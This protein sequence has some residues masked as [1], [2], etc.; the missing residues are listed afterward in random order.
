M[1]KIRTCDDERIQAP[2]ITGNQAGQSGLWTCGRR[3]PECT[4]SAAACLAACDADAV[5]ALINRSRVVQLHTWLQSETDASDRDSERAARAAHASRRTASRSPSDQTTDAADD[6]GQQIHA[7][8][9]IWWCQMCSAHSRTAVQAP[10][11]SSG[12]ALAAA[13]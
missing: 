2:A 1:G 10:A 8:S 6:N 4:L 13:R 7:V 5:E 12:S 9:V 11:A 3:D